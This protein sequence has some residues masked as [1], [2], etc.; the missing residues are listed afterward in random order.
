MQLE[1]RVEHPGEGRGAVQKVWVH[2]EVMVEERV[3]LLLEVDSS[4]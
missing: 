2:L 3:E 4:R 1:V